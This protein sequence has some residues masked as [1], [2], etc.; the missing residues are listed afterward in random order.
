MT[1]QRAA[2]ALH[3]MAWWL[4]ALA[5]AAA[6][7]RTLNP[8][9]LGALIG[10]A[11]LVVAARRTEAPWAA[12]FRAFLILGTVVLGVRLVFEALFG[13][14]IPGTTLFTLPELT[15]P[16]WMAGVRLGGD[17][18]VEAL[19]AAFYSGLQLVAI[20]ACVGAANALAN[21]TRLLKSVPGALYEVGVAVVVALT[22]IPS[23]LT[24]LQL[25]REARRLRGQPSR[26]IASVARTATAVLAGALERSLALA[27]A[28]DS[29]GFGRLRPLPAGERRV[30]A[31]LTLS[32]LVAL[33]VGGYALL[34][35]STSPLAAAALLALGATLALTGLHRANRRAVRTVYRPDPWRWPETVTAA[36]GSITVAVYTVA[37]VV[38]PAT[39]LPT[40]SPL[41]W[42]ALPLVPLLATLL[43]AA[44]ALA[45]PPVPS[46]SGAGTSYPVQ[47]PASDEHLPEPSKAVAA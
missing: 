4:W 10:V 12:S 45:A 6:A 27:A 30:T 5:L 23:A 36:S 25:I 14:P 15:L 18:T 24:H 33:L 19:V 17:V 7:S 40:T 42:P 37:A 35:A 21:P 9:L 28:M 41:A 16:E 34:D 46:T 44:P 20:L 11:A 2:R 47:P 3:P 31:A 26:G 38:M 1:T 29:R 22:L 32:G 43:A 8:L 13:A 39:M